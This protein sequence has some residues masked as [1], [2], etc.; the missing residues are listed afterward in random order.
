MYVADVDSLE[1]LEALLEEAKEYLR[2]D[3]GCEQLQW[4]VEDIENRIEEI[5]PAKPRCTCEAW[6]HTYE[7][8]DRIHAVHS[9]SCHYY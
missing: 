1:E 7:L 5:G 6:N 8:E 2:K 3:P 9:E 4:D